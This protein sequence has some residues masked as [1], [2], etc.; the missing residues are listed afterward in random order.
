MNNHVP[1]VAFTA[2]G[3]ELPSYEAV[4]PEAALSGT[5]E[6]A[7]LVIVGGGLTGLTL[8]ADL[9]TRGISA[10]IL[11]DD[12]TVGVRGASSR[13]MVYAQKTLEVM[14]RLGIAERMIAKGVT[15]SVGRT[16][17]GE[18]VVYSFNR[19]QENRSKQPAFVNL[20]QFYLEWFL[21]DRLRE[22]GA[23]IRWLNKVV[24][25]EP[26][27]SQVRLSVESTAGSYTIEADFVVDATGAGSQIRSALG[28]ATNAAQHLDRWCICDVRCTDLD[29][30]ERWTWV[31]A[32]F[33]GGRA[34]W[35]HM[36]A[37][38]VWRLDYQLAPDADPS[39]AAEL[40]TAAARVREH[41]GPE[42][43]FELVWV[44]PWAYRTQVLDQF[45]L[46]R[47][48][49]AGDAAH[50]MSPFG[51]RG[52]N[53]GVQDADNL[54]WKLALVLAGK[55]KP[56]LLDS[57]DAERRPAAQENIRVTSR[58]ARFLA[59]Q[60]AFERRLRQVTL[61]L[62]REH[63]FG[64]SLVNTGRLSLP[65]RYMAS[66]ILGE[67]GGFCFPD[68]ALR[69]AQGK[70]KFLSGLLG[71]LGTASLGLYVPRPGR[72]PARAA[73]CGI[74]GDGLPYLV[75]TLDIGQGATRCGLSDP[76][77]EIA[78]LAALAP[79]DFVA[80]RP[81]LYC[82]GILRSATAAGVE[83]LLARSVGFGATR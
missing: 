36:M 81:D 25:V 65:N 83:A 52:G 70:T 14:D 41:L 3:Y 80:V 16:L 33:N 67:G 23:E 6:R 13:G 47:I 59:P 26:G 12:N 56:D 18:D 55:A 61:D 68:L 15:W 44:G 28:L 29:V 27:E 64:Q 48:F 39:E 60:S 51:A 9:A 24:A 49:F 75:R 32:P 71:E 43:A 19:A 53:S 73:I 37:D 45:R 4:I 10:V 82:G 20:Q 63:G 35:Q 11:D 72:D 46:G 42:I 58:T 40:A 62:S 79:G 31:D 78:R 21:V 5:L 17:S 54:G 69:D 38:H 1:A 74:G 77:G 57:Y 8:A 50:V 30:P 76:G 7:R 34:V 66:P 2:T 22:L